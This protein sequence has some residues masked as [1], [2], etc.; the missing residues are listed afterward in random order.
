MLQVLYQ[1][2]GRNAQFDSAEERDDWLRSEAKT[3]E[4]ALVV[5]RRNLAELE[6]QVQQASTEL[7]D[8]SQ[9]RPAPWPGWQK[10]IVAGVRPPKGSGSTRV[11]SLTSLPSG[12]RHSPVGSGTGPNKQHCL[13]VLRFRLAQHKAGHVMS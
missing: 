1:K 11:R 9:A 10:T 6:A 5:K 3:L 7:M 2:Q 12:V 13:Y 4:E 8:L